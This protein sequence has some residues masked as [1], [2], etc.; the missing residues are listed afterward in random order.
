MLR[1]N[2]RGPVCT[3]TRPEIKSNQKH[4]RYFSSKAREMREHVAHSKDLVCSEG[5]AVAT[6]RLLGAK[7]PKAIYVEMMTVYKPNG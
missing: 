4:P 6:R 7:P 5:G 2:L 1:L 3:V